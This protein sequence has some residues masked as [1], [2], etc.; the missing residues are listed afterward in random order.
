MANIDE[1]E[2]TKLKIALKRFWKN[3]ACYCE[4]TSTELNAVLIESTFLQKKFMES[5]LSTIQFENLATLVSIAKKGVD[6]DLSQTIQKNLQYKKATRAEIAM[7]EQI[8]E[9]SFNTKCELLN[10]VQ[11]Q[12]VRIIYALQGSKIIFIDECF[13]ADIQESELQEISFFIKKLQVEKQVIIVP[14]I[15]QAM[16]GKYFSVLY[17]MQDATQQFLPIKF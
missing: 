8:S 17:A 9:L 13:L 2:C 16:L 7:W 15:N 6:V 14:I 11:L 10:H 1:M 5:L 12:K 3:N 4:L